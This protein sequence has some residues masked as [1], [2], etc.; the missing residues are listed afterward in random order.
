[1][2]YNLRN[3]VT[4]IDKD[5]GEFLNNLIQLKIVDLNTAIKEF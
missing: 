2:N 3:L 5:A 1:M 4:S